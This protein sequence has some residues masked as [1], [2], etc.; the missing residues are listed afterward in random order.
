MISQPPI[1]TRNHA[2]NATPSPTEA[3][4]RSTSGG[5]HHSEVNPNT[6][7]AYP[8]TRCPVVITV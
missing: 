4:G 3:T 2:P 7:P 1:R 5:S 6:A 8:T